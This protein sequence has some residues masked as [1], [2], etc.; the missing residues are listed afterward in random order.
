MSRVAKSAPTTPNASPM[1]SST[2]PSPRIIRCTRLLSAPKLIRMPISFVR[3]LT[4]NAS[5]PAIP[6]AAMIT[7]SI[8]NDDTSAAFNRRGA[9]L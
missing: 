8:P 2:P 5:T 4:E 7:A 3:A 6:T 1:P 9:M